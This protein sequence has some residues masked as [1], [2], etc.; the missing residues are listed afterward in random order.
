MC[1]IAGILVPSG[2]LPDRGDQLYTRSVAFATYI[3]LWTQ[4][5]RGKEGAGIA[6]HTDAFRIHRGKGTI[7]LVFQNKPD[8]LSIIQCIKKFEE[9][10]KKFERE[11][12]P[13][14]NIA[15]LLHNALLGNELSYNP[16][17]RLSGS[18]AGGESAIGHTRY[19]TSGGTERP[20]N[21]QPMVGT[22]HG[23]PFGLAHNGNLTNWQ[24]PKK[25]LEERGVLFASTSDT[26]L[27][28]KLIE[29]SSEPTFRGAL[30]A[31]LR[32][33]N[34]AYSLIAL[35]DKTIF[36]CRD[37]HGWRP[38]LHTTNSEKIH[39]I[40]SE[41]PAFDMFE[42][43]PFE[44]TIIR[45]V[46]PGH[47]LEISQ[48][49]SED[50]TQF[51][52]TTVEHPCGFELV[53]FQRPDGRI[54]SHDRDLGSIAEFRMQLGRQLGREWTFRDFDIVVPVQ[55][56]ANYI[57]DGFAQ[58]LNIAPIDALFRSHY[59]GRTFIE[60][61]THKRMFLQRIK[62]NV[63][64]TLVRGKRVVVIEDSIMRGTTMK[65]IIKFLFKAGAV[66][67]DVLVA[68]PPTVT[69]C[70][71]GMDFPT[72]EELIAHATSGTVEAIRK[73]IGE[74]NNLYYI[75]IDGYR[76]ALTAM[77]IRGSVCAGCILGHEQS[78]IPKPKLLTVS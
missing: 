39:L 16:L 54:I 53:Y 60:P 8:A 14:H 52:P 73:K 3:M 24:K 29:T 12:K 71:W 37:P 57:A 63:I 38:L 68:Y 28:V 58:E 77:G 44:P 62:H 40:A 31:S 9:E 17:E 20:E 66:K 61:M 47:I 23:S 78:E 64:K 45:E 18:G 51:A 43:T 1:G 41:T 27:I 72:R 25:S 48:N 34:G 2:A 10:N 11:Q 26:E 15:S 13:L 70:L 50:Q 5:H 7:D 59:V 76:R 49:G 69:Q 56:S 33:I 4:Q 75:S 42:D 67:I 35:Y 74:P 19:S 55:D 46:P 36:A 21:Y 30:A 6:T 32:N 65:K 22:F